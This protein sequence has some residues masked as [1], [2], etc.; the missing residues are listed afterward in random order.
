ME[1]TNI[2]AND[3]KF[4]ELCFHVLET[5]IIKTDDK[6]IS[7]VIK[8]AQ[9]M[10]EVAQ[11][12]AYPDELKYAYTDALTKLNTLNDDLLKDLRDML[13]TDD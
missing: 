1:A 2:D 3:P 13:K 6:N 7:E 8:I 11:S 12:G 9:I 5:M 10:N 4:I